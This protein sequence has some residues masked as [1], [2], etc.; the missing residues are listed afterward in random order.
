MCIRD[1]RP[2]L[3]RHACI[4]PLSL[5]LT[6]PATPRFAHT[7]PTPFRCGPPPPIPDRP[8]RAKPCQNS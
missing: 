3:P 5:V 4:A 8:H 2:A 1:S 6:C 7:L